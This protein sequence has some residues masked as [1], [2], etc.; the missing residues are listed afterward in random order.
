MSSSSC[1]PGNPSSEFDFETDTESEDSKDET[2][3]SYNGG[4]QQTQPEEEAHKTLERKQDKKEGQGMLIADLYVPSCIHNHRIVRG[5][6]T[7]AQIQFLVEW[8]PGWTADKTLAQKVIRKHL[9]QDLWFVQY[10]KS[11]EPYSYHYDTIRPAMIDAYRNDNDI[12][13]FGSGFDEQIEALSN[14]ERQSLAAEDLYT[15]YHFD[16][17]EVSEC[18]CDADQADPPLKKRRGRPHKVKVPKQIQVLN[19]RNPDC[20]CSLACRDSFNLSFREKIQQEFQALP[21]FATR[22]TWLSNLVEL[23]PCPFRG[24]ALQIRSKRRKAY[25]AK[26]FFVNRGRVRVC[27]A[28]FQA[29]LSIGNTALSNLNDHNFS[30]IG[31]QFVQRK[32]GRGR[33]RPKHAASQQEIATLKRHISSFPRERSHY[34]L[35]KKEILDPS[36]DVLKMWTLYKEQEDEND[37]RVLGYGKYL[38]IFNEYD[39]KFGAYKTDTCNTC[40]MLKEQIC[41]DPDDEEL[42]KQKANHLRQADMAYKMQKQDRDN[43]GDQ[44]HAIWGD[45]MSVGQVPKLPTGASF[46]LRKLKVF[47]ED[48]YSATTDQHSMFLWT[49]MEGKK[50]ANDVISC[51][52]KFLETIPEACKHLICWFDGTSSQ[53]KNTTTLLY[54]LD[55]TDSTSPLYKFERISLKYAPPG[56]TYM[57]PDRAFG[58][59]SKQLKKREVIGDPKELM[60]V[61]NEDCKNATAQ[62]LQRKHHFDWGGYLEQYYKPDRDFMRVDG[63]ALLMKARWFSFGFTEVQDQ[64][65]GQSVLVQNF[66]NEIKIRLVFDMDSEWKS[67][68]V[69]QENPRRASTYDTFVAHPQPLKLDRN[70]IRDLRKQRQWLPAKYTDLE[71]YNLND[72]DAAS[73]SQENEA[74]TEE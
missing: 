72:D 13:F 28:F 24:T 30:H 55:R 31:S 59:V 61:I 29:V 27:K 57:A 20:R 67:F 49:Q 56:H 48:F 44:T 12:E 4:D 26:Y 2:P 71:I 37:M 54:L 58:N 43:S 18:V 42:K 3:D 33:H 38:Q 23:K 66:P 51:L 53:L 19:E 63:N 1:R 22:S 9:D 17:E 21:D 64:E 15:K 5:G 10:S 69:R 47:N 6:R 68:R 36:L 65:T 14:K 60:D 16:Y 50:G 34:T 35:G 25:T 62:W 74:S 11:W 73:D 46:Y 70:R 40:D 41:S 52:H 8:L 45:M 39:L 7:P 32:D